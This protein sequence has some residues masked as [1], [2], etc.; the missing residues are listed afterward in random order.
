MSNGGLYNIKQRNPLGNL[1]ETIENLDRLQQVIEAPINREKNE[2]AGRFTD[3]NQLVQTVTS[4]EAVDAAYKAVNQLNV[5]ASVY[6]EF[7]PYTSIL[8]ANINQKKRDYNAYYSAVT[9]P[10]TQHLINKFYGV[11][12]PNTKE[13]HRLTVDEVMEWDMD[14]YVKWYAQLNKILGAQTLGTHSG[15]RVPGDVEVI[16]NMQYIVKTLDA[17][18]AP[19][20]GFNHS[21]VPVTPSGNIIKVAI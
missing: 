14:T 11:T 1:V 8:S 2:I 20:A 4:G 16:N 3:L 5:D 7:R 19:P 15:F 9:G 6:P 18:Q 10:V 13:I 12:D 17:A 21:F